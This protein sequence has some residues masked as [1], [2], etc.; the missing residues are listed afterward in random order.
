MAEATGKSSGF[1]S[2]RRIC[3][4][5]NPKLADAAY[6]RPLHPVTRVSAGRSIEDAQKNRSCPA[7][8][9]PPALAAGIL[10]CR[11]RRSR[12]PAVAPIRCGMAARFGETEVRHAGQLAGELRPRPAPR[13][14]GL[15]AQVRIS[16]RMTPFPRQRRDDGTGRSIL[17]GSFRNTARISR[18]AS[19]RRCSA[20][21]VSWP[22]S[23]RVHCR[24]R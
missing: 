19:G 1:W 20:S 16:R 24:E 18:H 22:P 5:Q 6:K 15:S 11:A 21:Q 7:A 3:R 9:A 23:S 13:T 17:R 2:S 12:Y 4:E 8:A 10:G 14:I